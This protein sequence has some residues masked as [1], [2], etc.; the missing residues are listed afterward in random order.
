[1]R[2]TKKVWT[3]FFIIPL[4]VIACGA[5]MHSVNGPYAIRG[6]RTAPEEMGCI[7]LDTVKQYK[8]LSGFFAVL[9]S[10]QVE[11][12]RGIGDYIETTVAVKPLSIDDVP[13]VDPDVMRSMREELKIGGWLPVGVL[14]RPKWKHI[15]MPQDAICDLSEVVRIATINKNQISIS[16]GMSFFVCA[17]GQYEIK[18]L[19]FTNGRGISKI[20][21]EKS[22]SMKLNDTTKVAV[23]KIAVRYKKHGIKPAYVE[24]DI[25]PIGTGDIEWMDNALTQLS[26]RLVQELEGRP[27]VY[28]SAI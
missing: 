9:F 25:L 23:G 3:I 21:L 19:F 27:W 14:Y 6:C 15:E 12:S 24:I 5:F 20:R 4:G 8:H 11:D 7:S 22:I 1:M 2:S 10:V 17:Q 26:P 18:N 13:G 28:P 16:R